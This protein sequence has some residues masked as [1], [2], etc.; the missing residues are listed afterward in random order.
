[1]KI[2]KSIYKN[3]IYSEIKIF[4]DIFLK[5]FIKAD[6][7]VKEIKYLENLIKEMTEYLFNLE[8][9]FF[10]SNLYIVDFQSSLKY[11]RYYDLISFLAD[12]RINFNKEYFHKGLDYI[13]KKKELVMIWNK[14]IIVLYF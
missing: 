6:L 11:S 3:L 5:E 12:D 9:K 4:L 1:M 13:L 8:N 2:S 10:C 7:T 14:L